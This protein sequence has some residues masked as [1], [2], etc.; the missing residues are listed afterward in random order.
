MTPTAKSTARRH[1]EGSVL[2]LASSWAWN[3]GAVVLGHAACHRTRRLG[4]AGDQI[5]TALA[6]R[7][8]ALPPMEMGMP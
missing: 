2:P 5:S 3:P 6:R 4:G 7:S 1:L 8:S